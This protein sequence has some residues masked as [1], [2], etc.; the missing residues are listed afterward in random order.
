[1]TASQLASMLRAR[2]VGKDKWMA[3]CPAHPDRHPSLSIS[4]GQRGVLIRCRSNGCDPR[5]IVAAMGIKFTDLFYDKGISPAV[6]VRLSLQELKVQLREQFESA[7]LLA[8]LEP[9]KRNYLLAVQKR[10]E[11][12]LQLVRCRLEPIEVYREWRGRVW[13][14]MN[15]TQRD[16]H[17]EGVWKQLLKSQQNK[18]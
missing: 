8:S 18:N 14:C 12:E 5:D 3:M 13:Q 16:A 7:R 6:R 1:V 9:E 4:A 2:R 17:L 10:A 15:R 11:Q